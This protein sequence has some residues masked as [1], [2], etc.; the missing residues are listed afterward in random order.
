MRVHMTYER[1]KRG[2]VH[3]KLGTV[4]SLSMRL[5]GEN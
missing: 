1:G 2:S 4:T 3:L 5:D